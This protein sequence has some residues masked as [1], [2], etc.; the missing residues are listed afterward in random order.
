MARRELE[1][2]DAEYYYSLETLVN[3]T[4]ELLDVSVAN[5]TEEDVMQL[6][7]FPHPL[8][9]PYACLFS[10]PVSQ[11]KKNGHLLLNWS[12][13]NVQRRMKSAGSIPW[14]ISTLP[15]WRSSPWRTW[16]RSSS[17][18]TTETPSTTNSSKRTTPSW[19]P[20]PLTC[21]EPPLISWTRILFPWMTTTRVTATTCWGSPIPSTLTFS[22]HCSPVNTVAFLSSTFPDSL[23]AFNI[24]V[25]LIPTT[26]G[27]LVRSAQWEEMTVGAIL[28][29][30]DL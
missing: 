28:L 9:K 8:I 18:F 5:R 17:L 26:D 25:E 22:T 29:G 6:N 16:S 14:M 10:I 2:P 19:T 15:G 12:N 1:Q 23:L 4:E 13:L 30:R 21:S 3:F 11:T 20:W 27:P 24:R 7:H